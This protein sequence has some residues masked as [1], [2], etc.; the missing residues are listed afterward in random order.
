MYRI[1]G[2]TDF[3]KGLLVLLSVALLVLVSNLGMVETRASELGEEGTLRIA[4]PE[5]LVEIDSST[6]SGND[7]TV[8]ALHIWELLFAENAEFAPVPMLAQSYLS[9]PDGM[10]YTIKLRKGVLF[11]NGDE[12]KADDVVAS[13]VRWGH[14]SGLSG[15]P[16]FENIESIEAKDD[17]TV[18][19]NCKV[20]F[21][22]LP[23]ALSNPNQGAFI[24]PK[25]IAEKYDGKPLKEYIGTGPYKLAEFVPGERVYLV[26]FENYK[27]RPEVPSGYAGRRTAYAPALEFIAVVEGAARIAGLEAGDYDIIEYAPKDSFK[28]LSENPNVSVIKSRIASFHAR[29]IFNTR[30]GPMSDIRLRR[31]VC[32]AVPAKAVLEAYG[33]PYL[34]DLNPSLEP[35]G[36]RWYSEV[37]KDVL[38]AYDPEKAKELM[39]EAGYKGE[40]IRFNT[41]MSPD[42]YFTLPQVVAY[43]MEQVG[44][45]VSVERRDWATYLDVRNNK[46][47][48]WDLTGSGATYRADPAQLGVVNSSGYAGFWDPERWQELKSELSR[49]TDFEKRFKI[50]E[51]L[52]ERYWEDLPSIKWGDI[53]QYRATSKRVHSEGALEQVLL[54]AWN[55]WKN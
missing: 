7:A 22:A 14:M 46:L 28:A 42:Y 9:S 18:V 36:T 51:Q 17:Y 43:Y 1:A 32:Y 5:G 54:V 53:W 16:A 24:M 45:N 4:Y 21:G 2:S 48:E 37:G 55:T 33:P 3:I 19:I 38:L 20:P 13:L 49:Y 30:V 23:A 44:F 29:T 26:R 15:K 6:S 8:I 47:E 34:W 50:Y 40:P 12:M 11:H 10:T 52:Q 41:T 25:E 31:A 27:A 35:R 39:K